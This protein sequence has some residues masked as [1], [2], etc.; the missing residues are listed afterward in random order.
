[1]DYYDLLLLRAREHLD[2]WEKQGI[3]K[4]KE[5]PVYLNVGE[6]YNVMCAKGWGAAEYTGLNEKGKHGFRDLTGHYMIWVAPSQVD[7]RVREI[8]APHGK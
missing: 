8:E 1:M 4:P 3:R 6:N 5:M 2:R 7:L